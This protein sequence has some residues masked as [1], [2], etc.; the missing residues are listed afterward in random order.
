MTMTLCYNYICIKGSGCL[1]SDIIDS[2]MKCY[3]IGDLCVQQS[4]GIRDETA[5]VS[6]S[7]GVTVFCST[8][9]RG[10]AEVVSRV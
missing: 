7:A 1:V 5:L 4:D 3:E 9:Q 2:D 10:E 6:G 8:F